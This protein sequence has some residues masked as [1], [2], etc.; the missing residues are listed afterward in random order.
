M[1]D[2]HA[3]LFTTIARGIICKWKSV[4]WK[5]ISG[6]GKGVTNILEKKVSQP[7]DDAGCN[8]QMTNVHLKLISEEKGV[9]TGSV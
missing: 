2:L 9:T 7:P 6:G 1:T 8:L 4:Q 5:L 3:Q